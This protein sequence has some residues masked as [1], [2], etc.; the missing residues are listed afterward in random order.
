MPFVVQT[1]CIC[2]KIGSNEEGAIQCR[3]A[4]EVS[5]KHTFLVVDHKVQRSRPVCVGKMVLCYCVTERHVERVDS[6]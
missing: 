4:L 5:W 6:C 3:Y 1:V 2:G